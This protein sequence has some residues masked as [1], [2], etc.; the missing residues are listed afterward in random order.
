V[1]RAERGQ[2]R[3]GGLRVVHRFERRERG[4]AHVPCRSVERV[5]EASQRLIVG[6]RQRFEGFHRFGT[7]VRVAGFQREVDG[8]EVAVRAG[9]QPLER[10]Q[11]HLA[12]AVADGLFQNLD[13]ARVVAG[14]QLGCDELAQFRVGVASQLF[15]QN[16]DTR[17]VL[18][19][20]QYLQ[21]LLAP[22]R[23]VLLAQ[24]VANPVGRARHLLVNDVFFRELA[25]R[26]EAQEADGVVV[27][28]TREVRLVVDGDDGQ[29]DHLADDVLE[30]ARLDRAAARPVLQ[31]RVARACDHAVAGHERER[32]QHVLVHVAAALVLRFE[33]A[34][35][36]RRVQLVVRARGE[37]PQLLRLELD[38]RDRALV[39]LGRFARNELVRVLPVEHPDVALRRASD[40]PR[41]RF[42]GA[43]AGSVF[44][45]F[46][47]LF[48]FA[49]FVGDD[50]D[51]FAVQHREPLLCQHRDAGDGTGERPGQRL[52]RL[53]VA[54]V[55]LVVGAAD[56]DRIAV[57]RERDPA[58]RQRV[59][60]Q[61]QFVRVEP[62]ERG[63]RAFGVNRGECERVA[64]A[65]DGAD[66]A[67]VRLPLPLARLPGADRRGLFLFFFYFDL[68][69]FVAAFV[70]ALI[71]LLIALFV[72]VAFVVALL[73]VV[74][75]VRQVFGLARDLFEALVEGPTRV[76][77]RLV[78]REW[79]DRAAV[80]VDGVDQFLAEI[81]LIVFGEVAEDLLGENE[82]VVIVR[83]VVAHGGVGAN[84]R[85]ERAEPGDERLP[86]LRGHCAAPLTSGTRS[87]SCNRAA[88][89]TGAR[90]RAGSVWYP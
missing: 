10:D 29:P 78:G 39:E 72:F 56:V 47:R 57:C 58:A 36:E 20:G 52:V 64:H 41:L 48:Q 79:R 62:V 46:E 88:P 4:L 61:A 23:V 87:E 68:F 26:F 30:R 31:G 33:A 71:R 45:Q 27:A 34:A 17:G 74:I 22:L 76:S 1:L 85:Q 2:A 3:G 69:V 65:D 73:F 28:G 53:L 81:I 40:E 44:G 12:V 11:P 38:E 37:E 7:H 60:L 21:R 90:H 82:E 19:L 43:E 54:L 86:L 80:A 67:A 18:P 5:H 75:D 55:E 83:Q 32:G 14:D 13:D 66:V 42:V 25:V 70:L 63:R 59:R 51:L 49:V 24:L 35:R 50:V 9:V 6:F 15:A 77:E 89:R 84:L 16:L 8:A